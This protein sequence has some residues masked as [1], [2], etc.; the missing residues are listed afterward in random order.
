MFAYV[1]QYDSRVGES[2]SYGEG[3]SYPA[4]FVNW[5]MAAHYANTVGEMMNEEL[6]YQCTG[7]FENVVCEEILSPYDCLGYSL[8][9][10]A[11]WELAAQSGTTEDFWT[12]N[13]P[14]DGGSYSSNTCQKT[15]PS[16]MVMPIHPY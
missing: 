6:C 8:P 1:M 4:Y 9:T 5:H 7:T 14:L 10:E 15:S 13:G 2:T 16:M 11:E 12:G 3:D